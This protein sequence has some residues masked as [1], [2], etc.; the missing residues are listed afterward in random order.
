[1]SVPFRVLVVKIARAHRR[2]LVAAVVSLSL[3]MWAIAGMGVWLIVGVAGGLP[4][5]HSL[6]DIGS[7]ARATTVLDASGATAFT[8][9][10]EQRIEV[11]LSRVSPHLISALVAIEDQRFFDHGG[12]DVIRVAGAA[13]KN[14]LDGWGRKAAARSPSSSRDRVS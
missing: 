12:V 1:M 14:L 4:D 11:P 5:D 9:F 8:I 6:R 2:T 13:W 7:M 3:L 10:K